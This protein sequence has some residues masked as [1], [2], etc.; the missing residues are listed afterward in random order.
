[1]TRLF[2]YAGGAV[3]V[4]AGLVVFGLVL[5]SDISILGKGAVLGLCIA[6]AGFAAFTIATHQVAPT[7]GARNYQRLAL[8]CWCLGAAAMTCLIIAAFMG[9]L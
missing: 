8:M 5:S 4:G 7:A 2:L 1:M 6:V 3:V 9:F